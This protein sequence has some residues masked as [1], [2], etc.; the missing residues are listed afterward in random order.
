MLL[1]LLFSF[2]YSLLLLL[3]LLL[4][5]P[6]ALGTH[7]PFVGEWGWIVVDCCRKEL[8]YGSWL[9][10]FYTKECGTLEKSLKYPQTC[11]KLY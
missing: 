11:N 1:S 7:S 2:S 3:L 5:E 8:G 6:L 4:D 10:S 9:R